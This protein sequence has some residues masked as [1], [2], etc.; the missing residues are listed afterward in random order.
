MFVPYTEPTDRD[1]KKWSRPGSISYIGLF[2]NDT[3]KEGII[4]FCKNN[5][6]PLHS[7][8]ICHHVTL[9]FKPPQYVVENIQDLLGKNFQVEVTG[10]GSNKNVTALRVSL[11][12]IQ[13]DNVVPH[14]TIS[15]GPEGEAKMSNDLHYKNINGPVF[16]TTLGIFGRGKAYIHL[17]WK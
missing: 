17:P 8:I 4:D 14:I 7:N 13:S 2:V 15:L 10:Y 9:K 12:N 11:L 6:I 1:L 5:A 3:T 16:M